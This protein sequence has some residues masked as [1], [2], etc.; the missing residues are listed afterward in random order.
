MFIAILEK[1]LTTLTGISDFKTVDI[2]Q[3]DVKEL[4]DT[5]QKFPSAHVLF[6]GGDFDPARAM[7]SSSFPQDLT[8]TVIVITENRRDRSSGARD[9]LKL[10]ATVINPAVPTDP[11]VTPG[12]TRLN[13]GYGLLWP[14]TVQFLAC[15]NGKTAYGFKFSVKYNH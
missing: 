8:W 9:T 14:A 1:I 4:L 2:W 5:V 15:E 6:S 3:G 13:T 11:A 10:L 7:G 12:L